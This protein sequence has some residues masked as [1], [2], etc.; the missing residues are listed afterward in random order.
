M[1][2]IDA[3]ILL[4][5]G[6]K[7]NTSGRWVST[8]LS[9]EDNMLYAPG[10]IV[11]VEAVALLTQQ[12]SKIPLVISGG[13]GCDASKDAEQD[14]PMIS[15]I[16]RDELIALGF[17]P[18]QI[19]LETISNN[20][21]QQ[22]H[23]IE[24]LCKK[25]QWK[26]IMVVTNRYHTARVQAMLTYKFSSFTSNTDIALCSAEDIVIQKNR[27]KWEAFIIKEYESDYM[28]ERIDRENQGV[29]QIKN[30]T[31]TFR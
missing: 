31:Y 7:K 4:G 6:I 1:S 14:R 5:A 25:N 9:R 2:Q 23:E 11:R 29:R 22:L 24:K 27:E 8:E 10:G 17:T 21:Y 28:K 20:T 3:L 13:M 26:R 19:I 12:Y 16:V 18:Q 15:E 30:G